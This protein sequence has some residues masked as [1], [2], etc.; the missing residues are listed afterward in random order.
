MDIGSGTCC[1]TLTS[2]SH[3]F[4]GRLRGWGL[5]AR[6]ALVILGTSFFSVASVITFMRSGT[7][8]ASLG[9]VLLGPALLTWIEITV[10]PMPIAV[11]LGSWIGDVV[12]SRGRVDRERATAPPVG[13]VS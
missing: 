11:V 5:A 8:E 10:T 1:T 6:S 2:R 13:S 9:A 7:S 12:R 3:S 4:L